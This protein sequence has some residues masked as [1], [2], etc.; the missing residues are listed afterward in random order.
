VSGGAA[1]RWRSQ[2]EAWAIPQELIDQA[3]E[4]PYG[5]PA[6]LFKRRGEAAGTR[7]PT[8]T[9]IHAQEALPEG[10]TVLDVGVGGGATSLPLASHARHLTGVDAQADMLEQFGEAAVAA[11]VEAERILGHWP[12]VAGVIPSTD[13][14]VCGHVAYNVADLVPF[15]T[16]LDDRAGLRVVLELTDRH[17]LAWMNDLWQRF[18]SLDR[19]SGPTD[20]DVLAVLGEL[21][22]PANRDERRMPADDPNGGGF[23]RAEDAV[24][25]I[26]R[27]LCLSPD[28]DDEIVRA[29]G[30][31]LRENAGG[32][33]AGPSERTIVTL[34]WD[35]S[36]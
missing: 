14:V 1:R 16:A 35:T 15:V 21:E 19:P 18:H 2:L 13:V 17:P 25:M 36:P 28:R 31:R 11:G 6:A 34:W 9:T 26:R 3:P 10:G 24:A 5:F 32:W 7:T 12:E 27:R 8:P 20:R 30:D 23:E 22:L 29:L 4:S 33:S